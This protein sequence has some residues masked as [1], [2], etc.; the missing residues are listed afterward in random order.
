[1]ILQWKTLHELRNTVCCAS[2]KYWLKLY[3]AL[4][5]PYV[6]MNPTKA[7]WKIACGRMD[8]NFKFFSETMDAT[9]PGGRGLHLW[10][11]GGPLVHMDA[12]TSWSV[13]EQDNVAS[14]HHGA[15]WTEKYYKEDLGP[16]NSV[17]HISEKK[18]KTFLSK[19]FKNSVS[20]CKW[21]L[22]RRGDGEHLI[23]PAFF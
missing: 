22:K 16:L 10:W 4:K 17:S 19:Q 3:H 12:C 5:K 20:R 18:E 9:S 23:V 6:R 21:T 13:I 11:Y 14:K 1:M 8:W 2:H 7:K 15:S